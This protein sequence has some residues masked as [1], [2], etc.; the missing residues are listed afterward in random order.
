MSE[1]DKKSPEWVYKDRFPIQDQLIDVLKQT[2]S[3]VKVELQS[4]RTKLRKAKYGS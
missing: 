2:I 1:E 3:V 4:A